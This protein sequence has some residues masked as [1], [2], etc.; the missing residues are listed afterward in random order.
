MR[1]IKSLLKFLDFKGDFLHLQEVKNR[2]STLY[3]QVLAKLSQQKDT[4]AALM[5][6][7]RPKMII[8]R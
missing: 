3:H 4:G 1:V 2:M 6:T 8:K 5:A 7:K